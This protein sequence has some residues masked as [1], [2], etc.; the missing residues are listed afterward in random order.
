MND[1]IFNRITFTKCNIIY[2]SLD[3]I[4]NNINVRTNIFNDSYSSFDNSKTFKVITSN[5]TYL[6]NTVLANTNVFN[7]KN[8][9]FSESK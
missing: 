3:S 7:N 9:D 1:F 8:I 5:N 4:F 2:K 6:N